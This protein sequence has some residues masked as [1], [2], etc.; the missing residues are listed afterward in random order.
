M[1]DLTLDRKKQWKSHVRPDRIRTF[2][3]RG[4]MSSLFDVDKNVD[5]SEELGTSVFVS[6]GS[7]DWKQ[8]H[9]EG[10]VLPVL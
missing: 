5:I 6:Q 4:K 9:E 2:L 1:G 3:I 7:R 8:G 10:K